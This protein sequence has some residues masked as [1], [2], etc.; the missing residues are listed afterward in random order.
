MRSLSRKKKSDLRLEM[1]QGQARYSRLKF[2]G[3]A[4]KKS[5]DLCTGILKFIPKINRKPGIFKKVLNSGT[6]AENSFK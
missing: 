5:E 1:R 6:L 3:V 4:I 2:V